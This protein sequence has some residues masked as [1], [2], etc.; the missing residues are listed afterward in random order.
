MAENEDREKFR[1]W[2][3]SLQGVACGLVIDPLFFITHVSM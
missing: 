1:K 2:T 3:E